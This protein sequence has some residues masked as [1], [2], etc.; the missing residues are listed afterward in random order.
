MDKSLNNE[1]HARIGRINR[2]L[3]DRKNLF[4]AAKH[5]LASGA[6]TSGSTLSRLG[7][8]GSDSVR[9]LI[10]ENP[11][12]DEATLDHLSKDHDTDVR[13][14]VADNPSTS[15][16]TTEQLAGDQSADVR[17]SMAESSKT[18]R[19]L[20]KRL[21]KDDNPYIQDRAERTQARIESDE[22]VDEQ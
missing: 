9:R 15:A 7:R 22:K 20:L 17:Y 13:S 11:T 16:A 3:I 8:L 14:A 21:A 19:D 5:L 2:G 18:P 12:T 6:C 10:A 1:Y 4:T